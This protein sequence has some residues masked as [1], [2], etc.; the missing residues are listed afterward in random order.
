MAIWGIIPT[1]QDIIDGIKWLID[2][3]FQKAPKQFLIIFFL[4]LIAVSGL[5][6]SIGLQLVGY[7]CYSGAGSGMQ[8]VKVDT[9][10][11]V[12]NWQIWTSDKDYLIGSALSICEAHPNLCGK[13][14]NCYEYAKLNT[15]H[16]YWFW[17]PCNEE[18]PSPECKYILKTNYDCNNCTEDETC[19][20]SGVADIFLGLV[21]CTYTTICDPNATA[22]GY[23][24]IPLT[25]SSGSRF[26]DGSEG[27]WIPPNYYWDTTTGLYVCSN[28]A[29]CGDNATVQ[30]NKRVNQLLNSAG[31]TVINDNMNRLDINSMISLKCN[32]DLNPEITMYGFPIL[33]YQ[34][35]VLLI[36]I[37][38]LIGFLLKLGQQ[39]N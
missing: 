30:T 2:N 25:C 20:E 12:A 18:T 32:N 26:M 15:S 28:E 4:L 27:C 37:V 21:T 9:S 33:N 35:W 24:T 13:E 17:Q 14:H 8:V 1:P 39:H 6:V 5:I 38:V 19:M 23:E 22:Y 3:F 10:N 36:L 31:F 7:H 11:F 34:V 29:L 16:Y